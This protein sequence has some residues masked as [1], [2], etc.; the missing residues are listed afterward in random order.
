MKPYLERAVVALERLV[1][2]GETAL[3]PTFI[4]GEVVHHHEATPPPATR[5]RKES[6]LT[7]VSDAALAIARLDRDAAKT[8]CEELRRQCAYERSAREMIEQYLGTLLAGEPEAE[9]GVD[10]EVRVGRLV[11]RLRAEILERTPKLA[12]GGR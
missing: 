12:V 7:E 6:P 8:E 2:L 3:K 9:P 5:E 10:V 1:E 4:L 11:A